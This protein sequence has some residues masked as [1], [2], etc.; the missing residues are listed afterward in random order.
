MRLQMEAQGMDPEIAANTAWA[1]SR[2]YIPMARMW[3][4]K[5]TSQDLIT[6]EDVAEMFPISFT[7]N[8]DGS[9]GMYFQ[10][11]GEKGARNY[12]AAFATIK[13]DN[14]AIAKEKNCCRGRPSKKLRW[15]LV[16]NLA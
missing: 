7:Q 2:M 1:A 8:D 13:L 11:L 15:H 6:P 16:G 12:D 5:R 10:A 4:E 9:M 14:L 3:N